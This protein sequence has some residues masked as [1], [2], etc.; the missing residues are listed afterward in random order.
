MEKLVGESFRNSKLFN[1]DQRRVGKHLLSFVNLEH[2]N[3]DRAL[4]SQ[5]TKMERHQQ[6]RHVIAGADTNFVEY[7]MPELD[8]TGTFRTPVLGWVARNMAIM[9]EAYD[10]AANMGLEEKAR[11]GSADIAHTTTYAA[12]ELNP[13]NAIVE[14]VTRTRS[15]RPNPWERFIGTSIDARRV[16]T[17]EAM[18]QEMARHPDGTHIAYLGA[19]AHVYRVARNLL[20]PQNTYDR[21]KVSGYVDA[22]RDVQPPDFRPYQSD[23]TEWHPEMPILI[24]AP[25]LEVATAQALFNAVGQD[26]L[27]QRLGNI[28]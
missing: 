2:I 18:R 15:R 16:L 28:S 20:N 21:L 19:A 25:R 11:M 1:V 14:R 13:Y 7:F 5:A 22:T 26:A 10:L 24:E 9:S 17:A 12:W 27:A 23:G 3:Q 6:L 8:K 4:R